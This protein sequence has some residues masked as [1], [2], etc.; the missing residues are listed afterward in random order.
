MPRGKLLSE[1]EVGKILAF[2]SGFSR[3]EIATKIRRSKCA[4]NNVIKLGDN[5]GQIN[6]QG[7]ERQN[8][9]TGQSEKFGDWQL[10]AKNLS[11]KFSVKSLK[12]SQFA[13]FTRL[14]KKVVI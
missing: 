6:R 3:Q 7:V 2:Q 4:V 9:V 12:K 1:Q 11:E 13:L 10:L 5:Y 14:S 8:Q